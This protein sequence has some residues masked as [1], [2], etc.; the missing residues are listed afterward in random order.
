MPKGF[1][2]FARLLAA[3]SVPLRH[4]A[5]ECE[6][7]EVHGDDDGADGDAEEADHDR[8]DERQ[9]ARDGRVNFLFVEVCDLAEHGI[10]RA[11][12]F[13]D[14]DH[15]RNHVGEYV[16]RAQR[17]DERLAA[18]NAHANLVYRL[19]E[20]DVSGGARSDVERLEDGH[21]RRKK[22]RERAREARDGDLAKDGPDN[23]N[24]QEQPV[25][26]SVAFR[27][28][29]VGANDDDEGDDYTEDDESANACEEVANADDDARRERELFAG[30]EQAREDALERRD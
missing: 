18:L 11:G 10:E 24:F 14:A 6:E 1:N 17:L 25:N 16:A 21:A 2:S 28:L 8:L 22:R 19:F 27:R 13:A 4:L 26:Q 3:S 29:V 23:R 15:L 20:N 30:A 12:L 7:W 9:K 5:D